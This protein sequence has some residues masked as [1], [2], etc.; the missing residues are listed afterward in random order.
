M[1]QLSRSMMERYEIADRRP[2]TLRAVIF[3]AD[4]LMLGAVARMLDR[5]NESGA[6]LGAA[7]VTGKAAALNAQDGMFTMLIRGESMDGQVTREERVVQSVLLAADPREDEKK[8][9][10]LGLLPELEFVFVDAEADAA[11]SRLLAQLLYARFCGG[12]AAPELMLVTQYPRQ[13]RPEELI[14]A[15]CRLTAGWDRA[16]DFCAWL[17]GAGA[18]R[19]FC[20]SLSG[21]LS[22]S[23]LKQAQHQMN[24]REDFLAWGEPQL[25]CMLDGEAPERLQSACTGGDCT[26]ALERKARVFDAAVFLCTAAGYLCGRNNFAEV[27]KDEEMRSW[28]GH[29][30]FDEILPC[31]GVPREEIAPA[32]ISAF[33]RL[34]NPMNDMPLL[35]VGRNCMRTFRDSILPSM[36]TYADRTLEAPRGLAFALAAAIMLCAGARANE[37]GEYEVLR[38]DGRAVLHDDPDILEAFSR[39]SHDMP[40]ETLAYAALADRNIWGDDLREIDGLEMRVAYDLSAIQRIGFR[41]SL[42][43]KLLEWDD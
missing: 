25:T 10:A 28:I 43:L 32:V 26:L 33:E 40:P 8:F 21:E 12:M 35:D 17:R 5:A 13:Q 14:D 6:D 27:L 3:G 24:Y 20:D 16:A 7:C 36:Q 41:E 1:V 4:R 15:L 9:L 42:K 31:L 34:E 22:A 37:K 11:R 39:L 38:G 2:Q 18:R 19:L 30:F 29:A 23:E